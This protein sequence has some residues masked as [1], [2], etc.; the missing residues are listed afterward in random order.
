MEIFE[1]NDELEKYLPSFP[2]KE[3]DVWDMPEKEY[4]YDN[5]DEDLSYLE[6]D[7]LST[8]DID[9]DDEAMMEL[10]FPGEHKRYS[11]NKIYKSVPDAPISNGKVVETGKAVFK[12]LA[13]KG[14]DPKVLSAI[15][16]NGV[17]ESNL[18]PAELGDHGTAFGINQ[19]RF[20]KAD[21]FNKEYSILKNIPESLDKHVIAQYNSVKNNYPGIFNKVKSAKNYSEGA[22][23]YGRDYEKPKYLKNDRGSYAQMVTMQSGGD[24]ED[25]PVYQLANPF[26]KYETNGKSLFSNN[27]RTQIPFMDS[28]NHIGYSPGNFNLQA[29]VPAD[30]GRH[31]DQSNIQYSS[32]NTKNTTLDTKG[33]F[34]LSNLDPTGIT[35]LGKVID[36]KAADIF[37]NF[38]TAFNASKDIRNLIAKTTDSGLTGA[39]SI[40]S[41]AEN[42]R[43]FRK[44]LKNMYK[45][46][47]SDYFNA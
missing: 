14:Y 35:Q 21:Y 40:L 38:N 27:N 44:Q 12:R 6:D 30:F 7:D 17:V 33:G 39:V 25:L 3:E 11:T 47:Y 37:N 24:F 32:D 26:N 10:L 2:E 23:I 1:T 42:D 9:E 41:E 34:D 13:Q 29:T 19:N 46:S 15:I 45:E 4:D 36:G 22:M 16:G 43:L 31:W 18:N 20:E 5:I 28:T 8:E